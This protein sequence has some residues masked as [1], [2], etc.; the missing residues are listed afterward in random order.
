MVER[1]RFVMMVATVIVIEMVIVIVYKHG[2]AV[3]MRV[4]DATASQAARDRKTA[5]MD[6]SGVM[7]SAP[8]K[9]RAAAC[10]LRPSMSRL[11]RTS[12]H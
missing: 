9:T 5:V 7:G 4:A 6:G 1:K 11:E 12:R 8:I 10:T 2:W 3:G